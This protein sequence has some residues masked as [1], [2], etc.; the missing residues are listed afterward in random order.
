MASKLSLL[1][2]NAFRSSSSTAFPSIG[3]R[4]P[5]HKNLC[6]TSEAD[7]DAGS[8]S[9][10]TTTVS[11]EDQKDSGTGLVFAKLFPAK[12]NTLKTDVIHFLEGCDLSTEDI[13]VEYNR[14]YNPIAM[15]L[16]F[17]SH[18]AFDAAVRTVVRKGRLYRME[19]IFTVNSD[20]WDLMESFN[21]KV[22][23]LQGLPINANM[24][25]IDRF[26][27]GCNITD[28]RTFV[29]PGFPDPTKSALVRF[30][31]IHEAMNAYRIKNHGFILNNPIGM[32][33]LQ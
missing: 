22:V 1:L 3:R 10:S 4:V 25:D 24:E 18:S 2:G 7:A 16:Q 23:L 19:K 17:S 8:S 13:K 21:G 31:T 9:S 12:K 14:D 29:R 32:Q 26:L 5:P 6:T 28:I 33:V 20:N 27:S 15:T 11:A 30:P